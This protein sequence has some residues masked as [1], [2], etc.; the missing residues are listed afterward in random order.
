MEN[1]SIIGVLVINTIELV[2][3]WTIAYYIIP[4]ARNNGYA[5]EALYGVIDMIRRHKIFDLQQTDLMMYLKKWLVANA[6][7]R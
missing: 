7:R 3:S 4:S 6:S 5:K 1:D 2:D